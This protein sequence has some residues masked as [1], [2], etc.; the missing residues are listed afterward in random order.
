AVELCKVAKN[1]LR[2]DNSFAWLTSLWRHESVS[3]WIDIEN[4]LVQWSHILGVD[5][6]VFKGSI[7]N[8]AIR[9]RN[10][11]QTLLHIDN[12]STLT[13]IANLASAYR[14]EGRG[15][16]AE[17]LFAQVMETSKRVLGIEHPSTLTS[18]ANLASTFLSQGRW[19]EAEDLF[20]KVM[21]TRKRVL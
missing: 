15:E 12:P 14:N 8:V 21:E 3:N 16:E 6:N 4:R 11:Q 2:S 5:E 20:V 7:H 18:I 9:N 13:S 19:K 17:D 10:Y 1:Y